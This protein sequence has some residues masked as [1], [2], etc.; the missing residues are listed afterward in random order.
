MAD[1]MLRAT[2]AG[3]EIRAFAVNSHD[4]VEKARVAH[5]T[6]PVV[7]AALGRTLSAAAMMGLMM[8][9][10]RDLL[11]IHIE[12]QGPMKGLNVT[13]DS[14]GNVKGYPF[15]ADVDIPPNYLGKLDVGGALGYGTMMI[16]KDLGLKDPY[17][18]S[19]DLLSGEIA[20]D[21][22]LYFASSEQIP[23]S[24]GLGVLVDRDC[25]V[26]Q[27][28]GFIIQLMPGVT[29]EVIDKL[30]A[31]IQ[32]IRSVTEMFEAGMGPEEILEEILGDFGL[33][34][35]DKV[36]I[37][38]NCDCNE[39]KVSKAIASIDKKDLQSIIDDGEPIEIKCQFC[40]HR[41]VFPVDRL[42]EML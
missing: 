37:G 24:V 36:E 19:V 2:A 29:D 8:K 4:T 30:E 35:L 14:H 33:E 12:G 3:G 16:I 5:D 11:T 6:A 18:G 41:Y 28:G 32:E 7:T 39:D 23:S 38:F 27:A 42:K 17:V 9:G 13:A 15:V 22:T 10:D 34:I 26:R 40:N 31:K 25:S 1:Y 21:L 20:D